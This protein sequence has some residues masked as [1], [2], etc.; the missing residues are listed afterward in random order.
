MRRFILPVMPKKSGDCLLVGKDAHYLSRVL[1]LEPG[2]C[3]EAEGPDGS[4]YEARI[5]SIR[6]EG[7]KLS[8]SRNPVE[9][10]LDSALV[11]SPKTRISLYQCLP[12]GG[13]M[14]LIV[15][16]AVEA[17]VARIIPL[18][19]DHSIPRH[20]GRG[21]R[22]ERIVKEA[23]QQSGS[24]VDS[25]VEEPRS[26][27]EAP[28]DWADRGPAFFFHEKPLA[29]TSLHLY[30]NSIPTEAAVLVGP[31]GG[32]SPGETELLRSRL[33][34]PV[35]LGPNILRA[36]TAAIYA[37]A[38]VQIILLEQ[39]TWALKPDFPQSE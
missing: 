35:H 8:L 17:G 26:L 29:E 34:K 39:H 22:W 2:D 31:E 30:L 28:D 13:K 6:A 27:A 16:Q 4:V 1:R 19:S 5:C 7:I 32:L 14:D 3:F 36:E 18:Y 21:E 33:W 10:P 37:I 38:A 20:S 11:L 25:R 15:R 23:R 24:P 12:K 9:A